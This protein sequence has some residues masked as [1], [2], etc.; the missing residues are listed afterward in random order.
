MVFISS[1]LMKPSTSNVT[2]R[3]RQMS[4]QLTRSILA[5]FAILTIASCNRPASLNENEKGGIVKDIR[6]ALDNYHNDVKESG[7]TAEFKY[8]DNSPEFF[9]VPPGYTSAISYDSVVTILKQNAPRYRSIINSFDKLRII[10]LSNELASYTAQLTSTM[11]DTS[12]KATTFSLV[13]TGV[14]IKRQDGWK[15]LNGQTSMLNQ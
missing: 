5:I 4:R 1:K 2:G 3:N 10:P 13:E 15:L 12:G 9:W 7:L 8:L 6:Q 14:L 11:T